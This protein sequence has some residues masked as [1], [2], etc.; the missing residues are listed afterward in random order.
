MQA[1]RLFLMRARCTTIRQSLA[2]RQFPST[3]F[4][5]LI[6]T[7]CNKHSD[8]WKT[9]QRN[10]HF[11]LPRCYN[12]THLIKTWTGVLAYVHALRQCQFS[13]LVHILTQNI[14]NFSTTMCL[15]FFVHNFC[16]R[17]SLFIMFILNFTRNSNVFT[18]GY[19][20]VAG[21]HPQMEIY[22]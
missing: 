12:F 20:V 3:V 6:D 18:K 9:T 7:R 11:T 5:Y 2:E 4:E 10:R 14:I 22:N 21:S 16:C 17:S 1:E 15:V 8:A 19:W 13:F